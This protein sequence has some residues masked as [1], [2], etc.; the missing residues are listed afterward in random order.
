MNTLAIDI[1]RTFG[2]GTQIND[3]NTRSVRY[4]ALYSL[5]A[6]ALIV[7]TCAFLSFCDCVDLDVHYA[8]DWACWIGNGMTNLVS[9]GVPV[10]A[11]L[12]T[13]AILFLLS[14]TGV[15]KTKRASE[16]MNVKQG[17]SGA[18]A[19]TRT[20]LILYLKVRKRNRHGRSVNWAGVTYQ[21]STNLTSQLQCITGST[22][23]HAWSLL[24][25]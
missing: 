25:S 10:M 19:K 4:Y 3:P 13:N 2:I 8:S 20:D 1:Y 12:C 11:V 22:V 15:M 23:F 5:G 24:F 17:Q 7:G 14:V 18:A 21:A 9:F 16:K 6:P